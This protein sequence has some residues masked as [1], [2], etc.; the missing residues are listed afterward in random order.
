MATEE[1]VELQ[2]GFP[3]EVPEALWTRTKCGGFVDRSSVAPLD[4]SWAC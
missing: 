3:S 2:L 4:G 1:E